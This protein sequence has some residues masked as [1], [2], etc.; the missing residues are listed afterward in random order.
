V[1]SKIGRC[2]PTPQTRQKLSSSSPVPVAFAA[3]VL[4]L[5]G[6]SAASAAAGTE[7]KQPLC[8]DRFALS[9]HHEQG[10]TLLRQLEEQ[11]YTVHSSGPGYAAVSHCPGGNADSLQQQQQQQQQQPER[12]SLLE[13]AAQA[14]AA[15]HQGIRQRRHLRALAGLEGMH[16]VEPDVLR[17]LH[18]P[19][20]L[21]DSRHQLQQQE[22]GPVSAAGR[23]ALL[24]RRVLRSVFGSA[25]LRGHWSGARQGPPGTAYTSWE[26]DQTSCSLK[27][28]PLGDYA[29]AEVMPWGVRAVEGDSTKVP[30]KTAGSGVTVCIIDSGVWSGHPDLKNNTLS[31]CG[32]AAGG[33]ASGTSAG[34]TEMCPFTWDNDVVAHGTHVAGTIAAVRNGRGVVGVIPGGADIF[35]VRIW[36]TSGDVSQGQGLYASD[37]V[38]AYAACEARLDQLQA[39]KPGQKQRMVVSMSFGSA[40]PLTVERMWFERAAAR[41]GK[42]MLFVAR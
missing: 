36:N 39:L 27:D 29:G 31:G 21:G 22:E 33:Q 5:L 30:T 12:R 3:V 15:A 2:R 20:P 41:R 9:F 10:S 28:E 37:L 32:M 38:R 23:L 40:G 7:Q 42:D 6:S 26:L 8:G 13:S 24:T 4:L 14:V 18:R 25:T 11:G 34:D 35:A 1:S 19:A 17:Y 16:T